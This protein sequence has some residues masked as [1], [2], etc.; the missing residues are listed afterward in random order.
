MMFCKKLENLLLGY[1]KYNFNSNS[2]IDEIID[3]YKLK[4]S[5]IGDVMVLS[6]IFDYNTNS[7]VYSGIGDNINSSI[8]SLE[9]DLLE[10]GN[11]YTDESLLKEKDETK[12]LK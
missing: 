7:I 12:S 1:D 9:K 11:T 4:I 8:K 5:R 3:D 10:K 6:I 2:I